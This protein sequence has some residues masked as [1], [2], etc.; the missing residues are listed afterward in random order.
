MNNSGTGELIN[1]PKFALITGASSGIGREFAIQLAEKGYNLLLTARREKKLQELKEKVENTNNISADIIIADLSTSK[2]V[3]KVIK[4]IQDC[5]NLEVLVNNA[6]FAIVGSFHTVNLQKHLDM[7]QVHMMAPVK[8]TWYALD[9]FIKQ[10]KGYIINVASMAGLLKPKHSSLY[11]PTKAFLIKFSESIGENYRNKNIKVQALCPGYT[12][13]EFHQ[14]DEYEGRDPY[15]EIPSFIWMD[16]KDVVRSSIKN[17]DKNK[18]IIVPGI[19]NKILLQLV[20][21]GIIRR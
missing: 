10:E 11:S 16:P 6:G 12:Y 19:K 5:N 8:L 17:M 18:R 14:S 2:G 9:K 7:A 20:K 4:G 13:S 1:Q 3:D 21:W 15:S